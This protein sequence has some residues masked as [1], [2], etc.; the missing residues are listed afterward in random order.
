MHTQVG[1]AHGAVAAQLIQ[2]GGAALIGEGSHGL[3]DSPEN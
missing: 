1:N 3:G 2:D